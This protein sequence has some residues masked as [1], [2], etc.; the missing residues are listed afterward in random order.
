MTEP[1]ARTG[2]NESRAQD[3]RDEILKAATKLF[4]DRGFHETS[5]AEVARAAG[6]SKALIFWHFKTKEELFVA[7][8]GRLLEPYVID[9]AE[10][11][12]ALDEKAQI[13]KLIESY[14]LFVRDNASSIRFF[15]AQMQ[16]DERTPDSLSSQVLALYDGYRTL[17]TD[18]IARAQEKTVCSRE[19]TAPAAVAF[20]LAALNGLLLGHLFLGSQGAD[21]EGG[22]SMLRRWLFHDSPE[23]ESGPSQTSHNS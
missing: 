14:L 9:F 22:M 10:E 21:L 15:V 17:L 5:M 1:D 7:V 12:G 8:L 23:I 19:F 3:S 20:L 16:R 4:A 11:A 2:A 18:L 6:V 13:L